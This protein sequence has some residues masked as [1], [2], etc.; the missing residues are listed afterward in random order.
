MSLL[1]DARSAQ[2]HCVCST[3]LQGCSQSGG[4]QITKS[5][6]WTALQGRTSSSCSL[7]DGS[8]LPDSQAPRLGR[9]VRGRGEVGR[10][11]QLLS[12]VSAAVAAVCVR[13]GLYKPR[14]CLCQCIIGA[15]GGSGRSSA[16]APLSL[17]SAVQQH[18]HHR[19]G[20]MTLRRSAASQRVCGAGRRAGQPR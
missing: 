15:L 20:P 13:A 7:A 19:L 6:L 14:S 17:T 5:T 12:A 9:H 4:P 16:H 3:L 8:G 18:Q 11:M 1:A 2:N 10:H